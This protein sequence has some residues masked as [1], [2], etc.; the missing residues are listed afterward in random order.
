VEYRGRVQ[1]TAYLGEGEGEE[2]LTRGEKGDSSYVIRYETFM[3]GL[4][5]AN[6]RP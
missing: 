2:L 1:S 4:Y 5:T 3:K 6:Q